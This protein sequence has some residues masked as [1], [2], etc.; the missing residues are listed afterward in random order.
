LAGGIPGVL[1]GWVLSNV[2]NGLGSSRSG[3]LLFTPALSARVFFFT[4][5]SAML[6]AVVPVSR[7]IRR[8]AAWTL[9]ASAPES[10]ALPVKPVDASLAIGRT[11]THGGAAS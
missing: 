4:V 7:G 8:D 5:L 11:V 2:L 6:A 9:Y 3:E 1:G 10:G